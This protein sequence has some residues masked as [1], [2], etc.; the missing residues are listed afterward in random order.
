ML[1]RS[2]YLDQIAPSTTKVDSIKYASVFKAKNIPFLNEG[3]ISPY[4]ENATTLKDRSTTVE[5]EPTSFHS[6]TKR[7][8]HGYSTEFTPFKELKIDTNY[9]L[10]KIKTKQE[11]ST[12]QNV[13]KIENAHYNLLYT[14][15]TWLQT[16]YSQKHSE[17]ESPLV[18]QT[19]KISDQK[20][21]NIKKFSA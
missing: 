3:S 21:F 20:N 13:S 5:N 15:Y 8:N 16:S 4:I 1:F 12:L 19:G 6:F 11:Q 14:P 10:Q 17:T 18:N 7:D 2:D 9:S